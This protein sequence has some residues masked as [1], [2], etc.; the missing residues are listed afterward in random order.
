MGKLLHADLRGI[1]RLIK[2]FLF[3]CRHFSTSKQKIL[4]TDILVFPE[5]LS[6]KIIHIIND[7]AF[8]LFNQNIYA[9]SVLDNWL[10]LNQPIFQHKN[11]LGVITN[12]IHGFEF[13]SYRF[14]SCTIQYIPQSINPQ[15]FSPHEKKEKI[16]SFLSRKGANDLTQVL[17]NL[18]TKN[19]LKDW[20]LIDIQK[21]NPKEVSQIM[22]KSKVYLASGTR[23]GFGLPPAEAMACGCVVVGYHGIGGK[24]Y[25]NTHT[26]FPIEENDLLDFLKK[27]SEIIE[28]I[29]KNFNHYDS[30]CERAT[31][32]ILEKYPLQNEVDKI[33]QVFLEFID[34]AIAQHNHQSQ[35]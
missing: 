13:L 34:Q 14:P 31:K 9:N 2:K 27:S 11:L 29:N 33:S 18:F 25:F 12:T 5:F 4:P 26:G 1:R 21:L 20:Q 6:P 16:L 19:L 3:N 15:L 35:S 17:Q 22:K 7:H 30:F 8:I 24:E 10:N 23:E 32:H 28:N